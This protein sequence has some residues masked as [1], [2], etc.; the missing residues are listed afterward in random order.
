VEGR[1]AF[2]ETTGCLHDV[3]KNHLFQVVALAKANS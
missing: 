1:G 2:Y 3:I